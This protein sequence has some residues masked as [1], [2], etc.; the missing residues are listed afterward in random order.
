[1]AGVLS[2]ILSV[3]AATG[4]R[5]LTSLVS[6][7]GVL[8]IGSGLTGKSIEQLTKHTFPFLIVMF[9]VL[10]LVTYVPAF[11]LA[12]PTALGLL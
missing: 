12:L 3:R 4:V 10:M 2:E 6:Y 7:G 5:M 9:I 1:M 11:S 8:F